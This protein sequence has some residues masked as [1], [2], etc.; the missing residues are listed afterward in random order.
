MAKL[1]CTINTRIEKCNYCGEP[2][3]ETCWLSGFHW[4]A[5]IEKKT[6]DIWGTPHVFEIIGARKEIP[7]CCNPWKVKLSKLHGKIDE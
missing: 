2:V 6:L 7:D 1:C 4:I 3:C 5:P